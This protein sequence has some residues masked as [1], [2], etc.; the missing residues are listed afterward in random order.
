MA[1]NSHAHNTVLEA[2]YIK[3]IIITNAYDRLMPSFSNCKKETYY[4]VM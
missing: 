3:K 2:F 4:T 1:H